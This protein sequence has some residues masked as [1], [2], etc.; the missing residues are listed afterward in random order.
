MCQIIRSG[1][2]LDIEGILDLQSRNLYG[3]LSVGELADGF[4][5]TAFTPDLLRELLVRAGVFVAERDGKIVGYV[6]AGDWEFYSQWEIFRVMIARLPELQFR[7]EEV[8]VDR[9]FQYG[10][11]CIDRSVRG[12]EVFPQLFELMRSSFA[13]KFPVGVTFINK[14]NGR[15]FA[16]HTRKLDLEVIDEFEFNGNYFYTLAFLTVT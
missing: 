2:E 11:V 5:T 12:S 3:N 6:L 9:S 7:G 4:V 10:P 8:N 16:A 13:P 15:S 1:M 14:L